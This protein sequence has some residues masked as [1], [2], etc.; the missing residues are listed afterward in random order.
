MKE[1][2]SFQLTPVPCSLATADNFM[3]KTDK[4]TSFHLLT[5]GIENPDSPPDAETL[6]VID[7]NVIFHFMTQVPTIFH[8]IFVNV[9]GMMPKASDFVFSTDMYED[10]SIKSMEQKR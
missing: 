9:F 2:M 4:S 5:K 10:G 1:L 6:T 3:A 7:G 8:Q